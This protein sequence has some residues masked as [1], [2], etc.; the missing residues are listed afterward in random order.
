[1]GRM[2]LRAPIATG[3]MFA[4]ALIGSAPAATL[5]YE[6]YS[7]TFDDMDVSSNLVGGL[8]DFTPGQIQLGDA[9]GNNLSSPLAFVW[10]IDLTQ[11]LAPTELS[12]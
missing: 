5:S 9:L 11:P 4:V 2:R 3:L 10:C 12:I 1:M 8:V 7:I 6:S